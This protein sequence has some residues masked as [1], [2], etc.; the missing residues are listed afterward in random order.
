[1]DTDPGTTA[2]G[3][4]HPVPPTE[5]QCVLSWRYTTTGGVTYGGDF[6]LDA[7]DMIDAQ[8]VGEM[9]GDHIGRSLAEIGV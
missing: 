3:A 5:K 4:L 9:V 8:V 7:D 2:V 6:M 1:M